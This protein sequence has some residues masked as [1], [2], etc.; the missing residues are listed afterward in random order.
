MPDYL[1]CVDPGSTTGMA[2]LALGQ[3]QPEAVVSLQSRPFEEAYD[4]VSDMS[5]GTS[6]PFPVETLAIVIEDTRRQPIHAKRGQGKNRSQ[7]G[8]IARDVGRIDCMVDLFESAARR[9]GFPV[10]LVEPTGAK[11]DA[12]LFQRI[13]GYD[14]GGNQHQRDAVRA[15]WCVTRKR[16][17]SECQPRAES[18]NSQ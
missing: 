1:F 12:K 10:I 14:K 16:I 17:L 6:I 7:L 18:T 3:H 5:G 8:K 9:A 15:G 2:V 4:F 13:T 11:W